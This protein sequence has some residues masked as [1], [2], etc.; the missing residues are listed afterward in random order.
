MVIRTSKNITP[1]QPQGVDLGAS[2][3]LQTAKI[4]TETSQD[5]SKGFLK[6]EDAVG[7]SV[8]SSQASDF[9][10]QVNKAR[11]SIYVNPSSG[12]IKAQQDLVNRA[13]EISKGI[14]LPP[15]YKRRLLANVQ[16]SQDAF[17]LEAA[18]KMHANN[19]R[20]LYTN[21]Q[22]G[23]KG[24]INLIHEAAANGNFDLAQKNA[25]ALN[26]EAQT[27]I[28]TGALPV[29]SGDRVSE[30]TKSI[31]SRGTNVF[32][33]GKKVTDDPTKVAFENNYA[34]GNYNHNATQ[35]KDSVEFRYNAVLNGQN[36]ADAKRLALQ[37]TLPTGYL[38]NPQVSEA[39]ANHIISYYQ[40]AVYAKSHINTGLSYSSLQTELNNL[41][42][43]KVF[44]TPE[45]EG[46]RD[47]LSN[48]LNKIK[49]N[50]YDYYTHQTNAGKEALL[51]YNDALTNISQSKIL[52]PQNKIEKAREA[53]ISFRNGVIGYG[54]AMNIPPQYIH[55]YSN[56][57][58]HVQTIQQSFLPGQSVQ[59]AIVAIKQSGIR[60]PYVANSLAT[61]TQQETAHLVAL[62]PSQQGST[63]I[64][65]ANKHHIEGS[66]AKIV[67]P[68][69]DKPISDTS[70]L[71]NLYGNEA[72]KR[73]LQHV[74][75]LPG[76]TERLGSVQKSLLNG[77]K[78][79][80]V[81]N[82]ANKAED[83][84]NHLGR[85]V[86]PP[87]GS[88]LTGTARGSNYSFLTSELHQPLSTSDAN[89]IVNYLTIK[90]KGIILNL[91]TQ[92]G[93]GDKLHSYLSSQQ[94]INPFEIT[95]GPD[96]Q[97][98]VYNRQT[99]SVLYHTPLTSQL[100]NLARKDKVR[101][102]KE[103][104]KVFLNVPDASAGMGALWN[105]IGKKDNL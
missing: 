76:G 50:Y 99:N 26:N 9:N 34:F 2:Q 101:E 103:V 56:S 45:E 105:I 87:R 25:E 32:N 58:P 98:I 88:Y 60:A 48:S 96:G 92:N 19:N 59:D 55:P 93:K 94:V 71:I 91:L 95:N 83:C 84:A 74:Q 70:L 79:C 86:V 68:S 5:F 35:Q 13:S 102:L 63:L 65:E 39:N 97:I 67:D 46:V 77:M 85:E 29:T 21:F 23:L 11:E 62:S 73:Y 15:R 12:N 24:K 78:Y 14:D 10:D 81:S 33:T 18:R 31:V 16:T 47:Y 37:G 4:E 36:I 27:L 20:E 100:I 66:F 43:K 8:S 28:A 80:L 6:V 30:L 82:P 57:D 54:Q 53:E 61:S 42:H 64:I 41:T 17:N 69:T 104:K 90:T 51:N 1:L 89:S 44:I 49:T 40:G 75:M 38:T 7:N 22:E 72:V 3:D 52:S